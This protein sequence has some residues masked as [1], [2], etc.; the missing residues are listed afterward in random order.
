[1]GSLATAL[2]SFNRKERNLVVRDILGHAKDPLRLSDDFRKRVEAKVASL[3]TIRAD[4]CWWT[5][6]HINWLAGALAMFIKGGAALSDVP[7]PNPESSRRSTLIE[8]NQEDIDLVIT[9]GDH[10]ILIEAKAYG[11]FEI[12][13]LRSKL[14]RL[15]ILYKFYWELAGKSQPRVWF[16]F[17]LLSRRKPPES[18]LRCPAW[19]CEGMENRSEIPWIPLPLRDKTLKVTRCAE[20]GERSDD[21]A[22]WRIREHNFRATADLAPDD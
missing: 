8:G 22:F 1:M 18:D 19:T 17:L 7:F 21:K 12:E 3:E 15:D 4:A 20:P 16:H 10:L 5:D 14:A 13:Q 6:Y 2:E 11:A 9:T